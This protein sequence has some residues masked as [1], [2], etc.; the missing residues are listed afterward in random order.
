MKI[1]SGGQTGADQAGLFAARSVGFET[2]GHA[3]QGYKTLAGIETEL[4]QSFN[5]EEHPVH[6]YKPR[7][8]WNVEH[9]D[10]TIRLA[11]NFKSRGE[12]CTFNAIKK[13]N[14]PYL[15]IMLSDLPPQYEIAAWIVEH[16]IKV[17]NIAG[18][19]DGSKNGKVF[20][21]VQQYLGSVFAIVKTL[22]QT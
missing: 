16:D 20:N 2:G 6:G 19:G 18:N 10:A 14:K 3:H 7:T 1:I 12:I 17:L 22:Q 5:V 8:F 13:Y 21:V 4:L 15:D 11:F 9:S